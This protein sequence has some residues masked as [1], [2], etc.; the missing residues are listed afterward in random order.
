MHN[1]QLIL[2]RTPSELLEVAL[3]RT[4]GLDLVSRIEDLGHVV[5]P[6][7]GKLRVRV[8]GSRD[9]AP[10]AILYRKPSSLLC[11]VRTTP[12]DPAGCTCEVIASG[13]CPPSIEEAAKIKSSYLYQVEN[14]KMSRV[15]VI[16]WLGCSSRTSCLSRKGVVLEVYVM[17]YRG[18]MSCG[19]RDSPTRQKRQAQQIS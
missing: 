18:E 6:V 19:A 13:C 9:D 17:V 14:N 7:G 2:P 11:V 16:S 8:D 15:I 3:R 12:R 4:K 5:S 10:L 1:L